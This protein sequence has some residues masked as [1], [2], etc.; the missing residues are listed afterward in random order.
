[1]AETYRWSS[2]SLSEQQPD[3]DPFQRTL[4]VRLIATPCRDFRMCRHDESIEDVVKRNAEK[5]D[6]FP[7]TR[8]DRSG[9][10]QLRTYRAD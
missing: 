6:H 3:G 7:V 9:K 10:E 8:R 2:P 1:M 5:F 4:P